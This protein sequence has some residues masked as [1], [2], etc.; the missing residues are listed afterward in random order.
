MTEE[1]PFK[2]M[3]TKMPEDLQ[4]KVERM[5]PFQKKYAQYRA[6]P[7]KQADAA[8]RAGSNGS[9]RASLTRVG[10]NTEQ[11][12][13]VK[14]YIAFLMEA[15]AKFAMVDSVEVIDKLRRNYDEALAL[16][17]IADANKAVELMA[18]MAGLIGKNTA[19]NKQKDLDG[20][21]TSN[22]IDAFKEEGET[23]EERL[24]KLSNFLN[25][26]I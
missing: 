8:K 4:S 9:S 17:K 24:K 15:R 3:G 7:M 18:T 14:E 20:R 6:T 12:E 16:G 11:Q 26:N 21:K 23:A 2:E 25:G 22:N 13:G 19:G 1:A 5:T 10:Y